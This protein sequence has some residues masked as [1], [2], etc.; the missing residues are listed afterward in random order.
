MPQNTYKNLRQTT[1]ILKF[2]EHKNAQQHER[3]K[4]ESKRICDNIS[5][6]SY[7]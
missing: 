3:L 7:C 6:L 1:Y 4:N 2:L 5:M